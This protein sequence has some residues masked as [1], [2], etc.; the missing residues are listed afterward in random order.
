M[1]FLLAALTMILSAIITIRGV[2]EG[3]LGIVNTGLLGLILSTVIFAIGY[4]TEMIVAAID[5]N[6]TSIQERKSEV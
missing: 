2:H 1:V 4:A 5:K 6:T 3:E